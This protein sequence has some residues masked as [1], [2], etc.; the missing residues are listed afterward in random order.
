MEKKKVWK[1][2]EEDNYS[3]VINYIKEQWSRITEYFNSIPRKVMKSCFMVLIGELLHWWYWCMRSVI[4]TAWKFHYLKKRGGGNCPKWYYIN[5]RSKRH[6]ISN[7]RYQAGQ[8]F[9]LYYTRW[10]KYLGHWYIPIICSIHYLVLL[11]FERNMS[12]FF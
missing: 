10:F 11:S 12:F 2:I 6:M 7:I 4:I 1:S 8:Y 5:R 3:V 9:R